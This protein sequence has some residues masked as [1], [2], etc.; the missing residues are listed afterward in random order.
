MSWATTLIAWILGMSLGFADSLDFHDGIPVIR[1]VWITFNDRQRSQIAKDWRWVSLT[2]AQ[3]RM[4]SRKVHLPVR[5][6]QVIS[7]RTAQHSGSCGLQNTVIRYG[8]PGC[9]LLDTFIADR[10]LD[11]GRFE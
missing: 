4:I 11:H 5:R 6:I 8:G 2:A 1:H 10:E 9:V 3:A 7:R